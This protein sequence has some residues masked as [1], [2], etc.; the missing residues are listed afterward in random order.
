M[1]HELYVYGVTRAG[2]PPPRED[3]IEGGRPALFA[4]GALAAIVG[5][6]PEGDVLPSRRNLS[7][8]TAVLQAAMAHA[9]VAPMRF[10][11]VMPEGALERDLLA[12]AEASLTDLLERLDGLVELDLKVVYDEDAVLK[13]AVASEPRIAR[14]RERVRRIGED[15]AYYDRIQ[16]GEATAEAVERIRAALADRILAALRPLAVELRVDDELPE[17]VAL[18]ASF[19]VEVGAVARFERAAEDE[20]A[21]AAPSF[22]LHLF[23]PLPA[24][25]F[26]ELEELSEAAW[27]S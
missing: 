2:A 4:R 16:L 1:A 27:A 22:K 5:P 23:G 24:F 10:G 18:R 26:V 15:A 8:H 6:A 17:R 11:V 14:L 9:P 13:D 21:A 12:R 20:A 25:S 7:A 19:L 3:G